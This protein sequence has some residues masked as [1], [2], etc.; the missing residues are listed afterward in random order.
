MKTKTGPQ[1]QTLNELVAQEKDLAKKSNKQVYQI[2]LELIDFGESFEVLSFKT[3]EA[4]V[5]RI[6]R[7]IHNI[8]VNQDL[9]YGSKE[10]LCLYYVYND[11]QKAIDIFNSLPDNR[12]RKRPIKLCFSLT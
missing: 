2:G 3:I 9:S 10:N 1:K 5:E 6:R 4:C 11:I 12:S 8:L 7:Y